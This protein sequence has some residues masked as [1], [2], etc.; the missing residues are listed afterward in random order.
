MA[1]TDMGHPRPGNTHARTHT[2]THVHA[3]KY[4][5]TT[6][7]VASHHSG[8][9]GK[10]ER[11]CMFNSQP[12]ISACSCFYAA[13]RDPQPPPSIPHTPSRKSKAE[14]NKV[15]GEWAS[16]YGGEVKPTAFLISHS[17]PS[18]MEVQHSKLILFLSRAYTCPFSPSIFVFPK[19][20]SLFTA[21]HPTSRRLCLTV[22]RWHAL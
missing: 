8:T 5:D 20:V 16:T 21:H 15:G 17:G 13:H 22:R 18:V 12:S 4:A 2:C 6:E 11:T 10:A 7:R 9:Y 14:M 3:C 1:P 19:R